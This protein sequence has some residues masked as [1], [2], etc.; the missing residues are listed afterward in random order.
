M[1]AGV[2]RKGGGLAEALAAAEQ[3][4]ASGSPAR[5]QQRGQTPGQTSGQTSGQTL[6]GDWQGAESGLSDIE[7]ELL[8]AEFSY[9]EQVV[10]LAESLLQHLPGQEQLAGRLLG[11]LLQGVGSSSTIGSSSS[12]G[13]VRIRYGAAA[14]AGTPSKHSTAVDGSSSDE[15]DV[16]AGVMGLGSL[17]PAAVLTQQ[18][19]A[20]LLQWVAACKGHQLGSKGSS[21]SSSSNESSEGLLTQQHQQQYLGYLHQDSE[22]AGGVGA[23]AAA[24][25]QHHAGGTALQQQG[26]KQ[27]SSSG[28][29]EGMGSSSGSSNCSAGIRQL[30][31]Y[32]G[33]TAQREWVLT[34]GQHPAA[35]RYAISSVSNS[36]CSGV[37]LKP[38]VAAALAAVSGGSSAAAAGVQ[39]P[40]RMYLQEADG[41]MRMALV[42]VS[43]QGQ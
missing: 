42:L 13:D 25:A 21:S 1:A 31:R 36:S 5:Q 20:G 38:A 11:N 12:S 4:A 40:S 23:V 29:A 28:I 33:D 35:A 39:P 16:E 10:V 3:A 41:E 6:A 18:E 37:R 19:R 9:V 24:A 15:S 43:E 2:L 7:L 17:L 8:L 30:Q 14:E 32:L 27:G 22:Y 26:G 34:C